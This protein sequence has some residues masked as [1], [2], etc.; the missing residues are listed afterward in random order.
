MWRGGG[1]GRG[2]DWDQVLHRANMRGRGGGF[3]LSEGRRVMGL[4][5][6]VGGRLTCSFNNRIIRLRGLYYF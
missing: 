1:R 5:S 6:R 2:G 3:F 4:A